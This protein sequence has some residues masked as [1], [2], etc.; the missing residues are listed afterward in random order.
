MHQGA[1]PMFDLKDLTPAHFAP[2]IGQRL[3]I[4]GGAHGLTVVAVDL[5]DS[6]SPR[7]QAFSVVLAAPTGTDGGQGNYV[8]I[9]PTCGALTL[10]LVPIER[11]NG[12]L[13]FE[14]VFN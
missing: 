7:G 12:Q 2:L 11:R 8:L 4:D 10:F 6:A 13:H 14:A 9:H 1:A 3:P 5:I